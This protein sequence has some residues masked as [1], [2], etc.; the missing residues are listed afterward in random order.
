MTPVSPCPHAATIGRIED[1]MYYTR[2]GNGPLTV[3]VQT[4]EDCVDRLELVMSN[5]ELAKQ[6]HE[7]KMDRKFNIILGGIITLFVGLALN[8]IFKH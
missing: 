2:Q 8:L 1:D 7:D 6:R 4:L 5:S 3:R